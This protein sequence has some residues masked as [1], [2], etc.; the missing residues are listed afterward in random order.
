MKYAAWTPRMIAEVIRDALPECEVH[1]HTGYTDFEG[2]YSLEHGVIDGHYD[3]LK[4]S[5]MILDKIVKGA[6]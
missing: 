5:Q 1:A 4:L 2:A 6:K 3:L